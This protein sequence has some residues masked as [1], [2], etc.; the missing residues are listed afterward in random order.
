MNRN[1]IL[2][3]L[4]LAAGPAAATH[5]QVASKK[6]EK[7]ALDPHDPAWDRAPSFRIPV[8]P[9]KL[10]VPT[11]GGGV[12][13][14]DVQSLRTA[15]EILFRLRWPDA[16]KDEDLELS[17]EFVDGVALEF[18]LTEGSMPAPMMGETGAPVNIWRWSA[19]MHKPEH[20]PKAYSDYYR[21]DG[22]HETIRYPQKPEDLV[23]E[24]WGTV[25]RRKNQEVEGRSDWKDGVWTV[26]LSRK[27]SAPGGVAF[28]SGTILP[29]AVAVWDGGSKERGPAKSFS[30]WNNLLLDREP[31][32]APKNP[33][34]RGRIVYRRYGCGV[35]HGAAALGGVPN[36][37]AQ[38][39]PIPALDKVAAGFKEE[40]L[41]TVILNGRTAVAKD[42]L[43]P[44]PRL[45][46]NSWRALMDDDEV[47][48]VV[49]Y[50]MSL[51]PKGDGTEF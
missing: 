35:C 11:G 42:P 29:I 46:M 10:V 31:P 19:A 41:K 24:G 50:L 23:A 4:I 34:E 30:V 48:A 37:G 6:T 49:D 45:H 5:Q 27:L 9:Q 51:M 3:A 18:P 47:H 7:P 33:V 12:P 39:D 14:V 32:A 40:E 13:H 16:V 15:T 38:V 25:G 17:G 43:G 21:P 2:S 28:K 1:I 36:P 20:Y 8:A 44:A 26:V 22:I